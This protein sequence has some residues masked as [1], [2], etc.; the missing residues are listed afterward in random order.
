VSANIGLDLSFW[1]TYNELATRSGI[2]WGSTALAS[3]FTGLISYG[4]QT[5]LEGKNGW[6]AWRWIF[7]IEGLMPI[8]FGIFLY[9]CLPT[10]PEKARLGFTQADRDLATKRGRRSHNPEQ[11]KLRPKMIFGCFLSPTFWLFTIQFCG[12]H[13]CSSSITNFTPVIITVRSIHYHRSDISPS[14]GMD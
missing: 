13:F 1:Y 7:L 10:T 8:A 6:L 14:H 3:S 2:F 11:P 9:F 4:I 12:Y 5:H